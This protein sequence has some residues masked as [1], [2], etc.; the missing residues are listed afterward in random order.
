MQLL[1]PAYLLHS[2]PYRNTSLLAYFF[3]LNHGLI[4]T[5][6]RGARRE[7]SPFR[8]LLQPFSPLDISWHGKGDLVTIQKVEPT[9]FH[10]HL[11]GE[12]LFYGLYLN[13]LMMRLWKSAL[14]DPDLYQAYETILNRLVEKSGDE[15]SLRI[16]EKRLLLALGYDLQLNA[17]YE[18]LSPIEADS[19]YQFFPDRGPERIRISDP[20]N[21]PNFVFRGSSL[22]ALDQEQCYCDESLRD[23]KQ[24]MRVALARLLGSK[25]LKSRELFLYS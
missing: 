25:P 12:A 10:R 22:I 14:P 24:I 19:W 5:I 1:E 18:T 4:H 16:F 2:I 15:L 6:V 3:T 13:E 9:L 7:K 17:E 8:G 21:L 23:A 20:Q 11:A